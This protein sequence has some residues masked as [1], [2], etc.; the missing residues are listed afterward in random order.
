MKLFIRSTVIFLEEA[1]VSIKCHLPH[2]KVWE[3]GVTAL[4]E[5]ILP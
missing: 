3:M 4:G 2:L 5:H 1:V